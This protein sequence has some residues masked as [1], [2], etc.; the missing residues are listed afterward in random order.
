MTLFWWFKLNF[1][2]LDLE[3]FCL[4]R[5]SKNLVDCKFNSLL[6][7]PW[8]PGQCLRS[9]SQTVLITVWSSIKTMMSACL[10]QFSVAIS[11]SH[12]GIHIFPTEF[13]NQNSVVIVLTLISD[14]QRRTVIKMVKKPGTSFAIF[15]FFFR[16]LVKDISFGRYQG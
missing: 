10:W 8:S 3:V 1:Y 13:N 7:T 4:L 6:E 5:S 16:V 14:L 9:L 11:S 12:P 15:F 2:S